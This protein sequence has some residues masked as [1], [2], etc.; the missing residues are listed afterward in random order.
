MVPWL[1]KKEEQA[2]VYGST[3]FETMEEQEQ[4][5]RKYSKERVGCEKEADHLQIRFYSAL[6]HDMFGSI[7]ATVDICS[8]VPQDEADIA[9]LEEP[10]EFFWQHCCSCFAFRI[11]LSLIFKI[12]STQNT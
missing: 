2:K 6:Y 10:G 8:I 3:S 11:L 12:I 5:I 7:F 1:D 4:W 9:I